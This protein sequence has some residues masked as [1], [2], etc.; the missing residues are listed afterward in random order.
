MVRPSRLWTSTSSRTVHSIGSMRCSGTRW[1]SR[2]SVTCGVNARALRGALSNASLTRC[3]RMSSPMVGFT[4]EN[5]EPISASLYNCVVGE[6][7]S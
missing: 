2:N 4:V 5:K 7:T 6:P 1:L 3:C